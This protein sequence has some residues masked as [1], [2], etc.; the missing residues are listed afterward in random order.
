MH[1]LQ[2]LKLYNKLLRKKIGIKVQ[3]KTIL[4]YFARNKHGPQKMSCRLLP[5]K[6]RKIKKPIMKKMLKWMLMVLKSLSQRWLL[7]TN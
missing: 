2:R 1:L 4:G 6:Q 5:K 3:L 7:E